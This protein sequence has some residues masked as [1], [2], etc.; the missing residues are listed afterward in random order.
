M[1]LL[2]FL[3]ASDNGPPTKPVTEIKWEALQK[4]GVGFD[5]FHGLYFRNEKSLFKKYFQRESHYC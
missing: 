2:T 5:L 4:V 3:A 1:V